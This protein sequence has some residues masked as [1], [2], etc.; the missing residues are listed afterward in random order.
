[1][2]ASCRTVGGPAI[3]PTWV[4]PRIP[5]TAEDGGIRNPGYTRNIEGIHYL[6][7]PGRVESTLASRGSWAEAHTRPA[8]LGHHS[9]CY[10]P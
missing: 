1:M 8:D 7:E 9:G 2:G 3:L 6:D 4:V 5:A 10:R